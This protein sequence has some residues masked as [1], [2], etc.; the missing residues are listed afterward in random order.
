MI[1]AATRPSAI[2]RFMALFP[3][4]F[5]KL[6]STRV[7]P[8]TA[9][10]NLG[11][12][13]GAVSCLPMAPA[14]PVMRAG[15]SIRPFFG[16]LAGEPRPASSHVSVVPRAKHNGAARIYCAIDVAVVV[17]APSD[18]DGCSGGDPKKIKTLCHSKMKEGAVRRCYFDLRLI[19]ST[20]SVARASF[21]P[22]VARI[23]LIRGLTIRAC[24]EGQHFSCRL[25]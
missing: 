21:K 18:D 12:L 25:I 20:S 19:S 13:F 14:L 17:L 5:V 7:P 24:W 22:V 8:A 6:F 1:E 23:T 4:F 15:T 9:I 11:Q 10:R 3:W 16:Q 2:D